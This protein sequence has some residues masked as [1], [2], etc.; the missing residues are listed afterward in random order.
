MYE[1]PSPSGVHSFPERHRRQSG[2]KK[3]VHVIVDNYA[4]H[5]HPKI[6]EWLARHPRFV[7]HFIPTSASWLNVRE[8]G[9]PAGSGAL[10]ASGP[11][12]HTAAASACA[13][14]TTELFERPEERACFGRRRAACPASPAGG[15]KPP[16]T[17]WRRSTPCRSSLRAGD[18]RPIAAPEPGDVAV[19]TA[20]PFRSG[21]P[22]ASP[23]CHGGASTTLGAHY[24]DNDSWSTNVLDVDWQGVTSI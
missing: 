15:P 1:A 20:V 3:T 23:P 2:P 21:A 14:S 19:P 8:R 13:A 11:E 16:S 17:G 10:P 22:G 12:G 7:F 9:P 5:K 4:A 18:W 6:L 24:T